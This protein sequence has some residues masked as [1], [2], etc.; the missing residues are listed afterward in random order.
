[1]TGR[2]GTDGKKGKTRRN[3]TFGANPRG[4]PHMATLRCLALRIT[5]SLTTVCSLML[6]NVLM[7][8][9]AQ[10][11]EYNKYLFPEGILCMLPLRLL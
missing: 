2:V 10:E 8:M 11:S 7:L 5:Y 4:K 6:D 3:V 9:Y 1:M